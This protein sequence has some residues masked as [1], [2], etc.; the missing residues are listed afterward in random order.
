MSLKIALRVSMGQPF[1][2]LQMLPCDVLYLS[3]KD[4][5]ERVQQ[6][7]W[8]L[9]DEAS[10]RLH[11]G[12]AAGKVNDDP[13]SQLEDFFEAYPDRRHA[14]DDQEGRAVCPMPQTTRT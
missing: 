12:N 3:L 8:K 9:T 14:A 1:W 13:I 6:R 11:I 5:P 10:P 7:P 2:G 4:T